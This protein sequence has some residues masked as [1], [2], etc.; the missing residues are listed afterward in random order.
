VLF[1][2]YSG[3]AINMSKVWSSGPVVQRVSP[4]VV[5]T[6][7]GS[8]YHLLGALNEE[9]ARKHR[10]KGCLKI[11]TDVAEKFRYGFPRNWRTLIQSLVETRMQVE[12]ENGPE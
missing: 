6:T 11:P 4:T 7:S 8:H 2:L 10:S 9:G 1:I 3:D 5:V 12:V